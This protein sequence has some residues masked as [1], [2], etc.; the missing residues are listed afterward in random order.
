MCSSV[1]LY[2]CEHWYP[3]RQHF[4]IFIWT[5]LHQFGHCQWDKRSP[6]PRPWDLGISTPEPPLLPCA[7]LTVDHKGF[8]PLKTS[9]GIP[10]STCSSACRALCARLTV[11]SRLASLKYQPH[12]LFFCDKKPVGVKSSILLNNEP[13]VSGA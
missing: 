5:C 9:V 8:P 3:S 4:D 13:A 7:P 6:P 10:C 12:A 2:I 1:L 11:K